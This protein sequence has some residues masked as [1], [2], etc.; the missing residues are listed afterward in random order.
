MTTLLSQHRT[1]QIRSLQARLDVARPTLFAETLRISG[2]FDVINT[3]DPDVLVITR[4]LKRNPN[5]PKT[6]NV[7]TSKVRTLHHHDDN[8]WAVYYFDPDTCTVEEAFDDFCL[9]ATNQFNRE[10]LTYESRVAQLK[11]GV[12][13][14]ANFDILTFKK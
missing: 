11:K 3:T 2:V 14:L 8:T 10:I 6:I 13:G 12:Q 9:M 5:T 4:D 7:P 1:T